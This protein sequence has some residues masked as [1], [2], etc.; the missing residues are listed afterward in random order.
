LVEELKVNLELK[1]ESGLLAIDL[2]KDKDVVEYL[3]SF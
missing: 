2:A 3:S 1:N